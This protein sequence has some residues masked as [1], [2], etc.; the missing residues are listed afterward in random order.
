[1]AYIAVAV[2]LGFIIGGVGTAV[3]GITR[4]F[5][6]YLRL[7]D[8]SGVVA[9]VCVYGLVARGVVFVITGI[10]FAYAGFRVDPQQAGSMADALEWV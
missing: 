3:K 4:K 9:T 6:R 5:E 8:A 10:F 1:G 2:G 7:A